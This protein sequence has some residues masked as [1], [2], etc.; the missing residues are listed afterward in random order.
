MSAFLDFVISSQFKGEFLLDDSMVKY[1]CRQQ[2]ESD[3]ISNLIKDKA[4]SIVTPSQVNLVT[5][6]CSKINNEAKQVIS[7]HVLKQLLQQN[8]AA[9]VNTSDHMASMNLIVK[10]GRIDKLRE[11]TE[12]ATYLQKNDSYCNS[13]TYLNKL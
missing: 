10:C 6:L 4:V 3:S 11:T 13:D 7:A 5:R 2:G 9:V 1:I 12:L 8:L